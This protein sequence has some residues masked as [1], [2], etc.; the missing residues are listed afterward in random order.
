[1]GAPSIPFVTSATIAG[2]KPPEGCFRPRWKRSASDGGRWMLRDASLGE[3]SGELWPLALFFVVTLSLA[4]R[5][6]R[7]R[8][9]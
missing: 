7:K 1:M 2:Q 6:F 4:V 5:R 3:L 8:L 9:D